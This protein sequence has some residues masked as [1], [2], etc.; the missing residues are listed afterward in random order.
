MSDES[1]ELEKAAE[2]GG[3]EEEERDEEGG[4]GTTERVMVG[5]TMFTARVL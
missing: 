4:E 2:R 3:G 5:Q 1:E